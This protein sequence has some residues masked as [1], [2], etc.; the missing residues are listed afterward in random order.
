MADEL[1]SAL[2]ELAA[3][4]ETA[5]VVG[6]PATR[7]RAMRR[8]RRRRAAASLGAG[9]AALALLGFALSLHLGTAPDHPAGH[10]PP[11]TASPT[12]FSDTLDLSRRTLTFDGRVMPVLSESDALRKAESPMTVVTKEDPREQSHHVSPGGRTIGPTVVSVR[13]VVELRDRE[14]RPHYVGLFSPQLKALSDDVGGGW[15]GLGAEDIQWLY[16]RVRPGDTFSL[17]TGPTPTPTATPSSAVPAPDSTAPRPRLD[18]MVH[19]ERTNHHND[20]DRPQPDTHHGERP[21]GS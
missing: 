6:G 2:R 15:I 19:A 12:A 5:P 14:G 20:D 11:A 4:Q 8:R 1:S 18:D 3:A 21:A 9:T 10:R 7:A 17:T 13:Y 16:A